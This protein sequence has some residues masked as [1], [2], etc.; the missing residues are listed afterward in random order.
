MQ[1]LPFTPYPLP[2][3]PTLYSPPSTPTQE[4]IEMY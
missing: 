4:K 1:Q 2:L 3:L